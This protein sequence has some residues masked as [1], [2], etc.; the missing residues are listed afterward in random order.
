[1]TFGFGAVRLLDNT[2]LAV[3]EGSILMVTG[4]SGSGKSVLLE[5][6]A[7]LVRPPQGV[8]LW[9]DTDLWKI[10]PVRRLSMR[11][12]VGFV[13]QNHALISNLTVFDNIALPLRYHTGL[14][15]WEIR[16][17]VEESLQKLGIECLAAKRP[18]EL[19]ME[20]MRWTAVARALI[21]EPEL[22]FL[23]GPTTG[24]DPIAGQRILRLILDERRRR[25]MTVLIVS[26]SMQVARTMGCPVAV[27]ENGKISM[28]DTAGEK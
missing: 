5:I 3:P 24:I 10:S 4:P 26:H 17:K 14:S 19:S 15:E 1:V 20:Q 21:M 7:G 9:G 23:D 22:L 18:E 13:F 6:C 11:R 2:G 8:V 28:M 12:R 25:T 27:L 16:E